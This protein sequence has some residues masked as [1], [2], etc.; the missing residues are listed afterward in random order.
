MDNQ[1]H[2]NRYDVQPG[3]IGRGAG[4]LHCPRV[5]WPAKSQCT[6]RPCRTLQARGLPMDGG[7]D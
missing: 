6:A 4:G 3:A 2:A 1:V 7:D 5:V